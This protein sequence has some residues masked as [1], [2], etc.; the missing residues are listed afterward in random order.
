MRS[1]H[2]RAEVSA[3]DQ[4][5]AA[6]GVAGE[7]HRRLPGRV[8]AADDQHRVGGA[9]LCLGLGGGVVDAGALVALEVGEVELAVLGAGCN[10]HRAAVDDLAARQLDRIVAVVAGQAGGLGWNDQARAQP[11]RL[12]DG[13]LSQLAS[14]DPCREP[15][16]VLD[17]RRRAGLSAE[18]DRVDRL[19]V[20][21]FRGA[22]ERGGEASWST[23]DDDQV[24]HRRRLTMRTETE[25]RCELR[26]GGVAEHAS[27]ADHDRRLCLRD[28]DGPQQRVG[29]LV[30]LE[31]H[32][33]IRHAVT[34][35]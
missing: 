7:E 28:P 26:I 34:G 8:S 5:A 29:F 31:V 14:R 13:A 20:E 16:V 23:A 19:R 24:A 33:V 9:Q 4:Q 2:R 3:A 12:E 35:E 30:V 22:V 11:P 25:H 21:S 1:R 17:P 6:G 27:A 15:K 18:R 10:D 32:P